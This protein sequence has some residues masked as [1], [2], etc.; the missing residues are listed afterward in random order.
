M[1]AGRSRRFNSA[2][3]KVYLNLLNEIVILEFVIEKFLRNDDITNVV[4][5]INKEDMNLY[6]N[7]LTKNN[8][9]KNNSKMLPCVFGG[10]LRQESVRL[11]LESL[12]HLNPD[13]V[14]I[15]DAARP[16]VKGEIIQNVL[17]SLNTNVAVDLGL[18]VVDTIKQRGDIYLVLERDKLYYTQ[19][20]QGFEYQTISNLHKK[21]KDLQCYDD[22]SLCIKGGK[23]YTIV[24]G[25]RRNIKIT[26]QEDLN[27]AAWILTQYKEYFI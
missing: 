19:T 25:D 5:V 12:A 4:V 18:P 23:K 26:F 8:Y 16:L 11:G 9:I 21:F 3:P 20:P 13:K 1:A 6:N 14:L 17:Q 22:I 2:L 10:N 15:H 24:E 7:I 27:Y